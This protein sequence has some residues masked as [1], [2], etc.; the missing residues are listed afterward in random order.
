MYRKRWRSWGK[1][2]DFMILD[3][4][5]QQLAFT[6]AYIIRFGIGNPYGD[7]EYRSLAVVFMLIDFFVEVVFDS[8]K[9]VL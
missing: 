1:H 4:I 2:W 8:F 5:C 3:I 7:I 9:N 6:F